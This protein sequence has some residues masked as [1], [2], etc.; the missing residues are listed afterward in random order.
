MKDQ[1]GPDKNGAL[2][3][4]SF[5][6]IYPILLRMMNPKGR[7]PANGL[8]QQLC[9]YTLVGAVA[10][11]IDFASLFA[12]THFGHIHYLI[13]AGVAF[14]IGLTVNYVLCVRWVFTRRSV[15]DKRLE[16]LVFAVIGLVGLG[17]NEAFIWFFTEM[18]G[19]HYLTSKITSTVFVYLWNFFARK[20]SLFR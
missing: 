1:V 4:V 14:L 18:A 8:V 10:F 9:R 3:L 11:A 5:A 15:G 6:S 16:F 2:Y 13:S 20:Y 17:L 7:S 19:F 12:L